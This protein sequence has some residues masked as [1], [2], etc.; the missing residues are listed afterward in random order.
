VLLDVNMPSPDGWQTLRE[1]LTN[2]PHQ[3]VLMVSGYALD[4]E[5]LERGAVGLL[6]KPFG[7][8]MLVDAVQGALDDA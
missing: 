1:L 3:R 6:R 4:D 8:Q 5:A 2:A 7:A